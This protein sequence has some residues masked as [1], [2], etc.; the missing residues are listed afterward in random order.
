[1]PVPKG[2]GSQMRTPM[3]FAM[4]SCLMMVTTDKKVIEGSEAAMM[5]VEG[6]PEYRR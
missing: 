4:L 6:P 5:K 1:M 3:S 2:K